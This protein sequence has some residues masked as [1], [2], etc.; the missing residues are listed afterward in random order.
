MG[1]MF[2]DPQWMPEIMDSTQLLC[3]NNNFHLS[4]KESTLWLLSAIFALGPLNKVGVT[5][6]QALQTVTINLTT[7]MATK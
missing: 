6:T 5:G 7:E 2:E 4:L 3:I 1:D